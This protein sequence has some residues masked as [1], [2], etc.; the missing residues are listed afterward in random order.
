MIKSISK[1]V[2]SEYL[3]FIEY[4]P[5]SLII[6]DGAP[7]FVEFEYP[8][9]E[10]VIL[11]GENIKDIFKERIDP[12]G[13]H[14]TLIS[15][16]RSLRPQPD[17]KDD[18]YQRSDNCLFDDKSKIASPQ[19]EYKDLGVFSAPN[20]FAFNPGFHDLIITQDHIETIDQIKENHIYGIVSALKI[21][22]QKMKTDHDI[23]Q[24]DMGV[25]FG[26][27]K[28]KYSS[29]ASQPHLHA[30]IGAVFKNGFM[31]IQDKVQYINDQFRGLSIDYEELYIQ[32]LKSSSLIAWENNSFYAFA[33]FAPRFKDEINIISKNKDIP[34]IISA[35]EEQI[36]DLSE[37]I[38]K[39]I[40]ALENLSVEDQNGNLVNVGI[41]SFNID[42][43]GLRFGRDEGRMLVSII[44][45]QTDIAYSELLSRFVIDRSPE[46]TVKHIN[47]E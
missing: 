42:F 32:A 7:Y 21:R 18:V 29:G 37:I 39:S 4:I 30:Q 45:R 40:K 12:Y 8:T 23:D 5:Q 25:N 14:S 33:P 36:K 35:S 26:T 38:Y 27:D 15:Q 11:N 46:E 2:A 34:N 17:L 43:L 16:R 31:P 3:P 13:D 22:A 10:K 9:D 44:P 28:L 6:K 47:Y 41:K 20:P 19:E 24:L 1:N